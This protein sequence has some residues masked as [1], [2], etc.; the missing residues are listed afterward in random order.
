MGNIIGDIEWK[1]CKFEKALLH[2]EPGTAFWKDLTIVYEGKEYTT[3]LSDNGT[4]DL[5]NVLPSTI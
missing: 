2:V 4:L 5:R 1:D 3:R